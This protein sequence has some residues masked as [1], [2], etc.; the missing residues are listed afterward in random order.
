VQKR[1]DQPPSHGIPPRAGAA[2]KLPACPPEHLPEPERDC[3]EPKNRARPPRQRER[4]SRVVER[5][6]YFECEDECDRECDDPCGTGGRGGEGDGN[7]KGRPTRPGGTDNGR[8]GQGGGLSK[9]D[10]NAPNQPGVWVGPRA[11]LYLPYLFMRANPA[12]LGA[13][14]IVNAPFWESPDI[15]LLAGVDPAI[16]PPKP[17]ALGQIALA[18]QP[19][20]IY[21]HVWNFGNAAANEVIV[22]FYWVNPALGISSASVNLIGQTVTA[23]GAKGSGNS[24]RVVKCPV[25]WV[26]TFVNGGHECLLVR[27]WD[28]VS[29]LPGQ[30]MF[31]A[32][33]NRHIA[34]RN[35]HVDAPGMAANAMSARGRTLPRAAI[36]APALQ[37]PILIKVGPLFGAPATVAVQRIAPAAVPW[38]QL[39]TG[40]RGVF[41]AM[42]PPTGTPSLSP[43][44]TTAGG[45]PS[46]GGAATQ[47]VHGDEQHVAFTTTDAAPGPGEAHT[48]R[49]TA[50]QAGTVFGGYTVV[51]LG[52]KK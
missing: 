4:L 45:F 21:A 22:E 2:P 24:H 47:H 48:Y 14:P 43:P 18:G 44:T 52:P 34:Q 31:D 38:L 35:I 41:P 20:T 42:A 36:A 32:T 39:H 9:G 13:R 8:L 37:Q 17:P 30:P 19:N 49:V 15:F 16:A 10:V 51:L 28:N 6:W 12:D 11:Q 29:D 3:T 25:A 23:L 5:T 7:G 46:T 27:I 40:Q 33:W 1:D 26:P 50:T